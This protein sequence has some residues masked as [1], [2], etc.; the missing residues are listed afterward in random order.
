MYYVYIIQSQK[1]QSYYTG[2]AE[3]VDERLKDHNWHT[4]KTTKSK[5]PYETVWYCAFKAKKQ[6]LSFEKYLKTG[7]GIAFRN[8][9]LL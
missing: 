7:S 5:A 9:H 4:V 6:A 3:D 2:M 1:D 8:R